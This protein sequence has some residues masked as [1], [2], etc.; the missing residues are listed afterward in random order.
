MIAYSKPNPSA[1][2]RARPTPGLR[3]LAGNPD[4]R[5]GGSGPDTKEKYQC[6]LD[7]T[8]LVPLSAR[9]YECPPGWTVAPR[10]LND[11]MWFWIEAGHGHYQVGPDPGPQPFRPGDLILVPRGVRHCIAAGQGQQ[12]RQVSVHF[13]APVFGA[14]DLLSVLGFPARVSGACVASAGPASLRLTQTFGDRP[15]GWKQSMLVE[16]WSVLLAVLQ[17]Q[18]ELCKPIEGAPR[19]RYLARVQP[20]LEWIATRLSDPALSSAQVA[21][22]LGVS[23]VYL[24]K[25]FKPVTGLGPALYIQRRRIEQA[26][27]LLRHTPLSVKEVAA[28]VGFENLPFFF[29]C[30]KRWTGLTPEDYRTGS[31]GP[32]PG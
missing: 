3:T 15:L 20:A 1:F 32:S 18:P 4:R 21:G 14:V 5:P 29:R 30:F 31:D 2:P 8:E 23:S 11:C 13:Q 24:R 6:W 26:S 12:V 7:G 16:V 9:Y 17:K 28:H 10:V 25:L 22:R 27:M 19:F